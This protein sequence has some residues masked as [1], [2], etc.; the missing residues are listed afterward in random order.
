M[1]LSLIPLLSLLAVAFLAWAFWLLPREVFLNA[2]LIKADGA[3]DS[4]K[5]GFH[6][7]R[8]WIRFWQW[9]GCTAAGSLPALLWG[10]PWPVVALTFLGLGILLAGFFAAAFTPALN[11]ARGLDKWYVSFADRA[12]SWPDSKL[13]S[14]ARA[15]Y[16]ND[17]AKQVEYAAHALERLSGQTLFGTAAAAGLLIVAALVIHF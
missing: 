7:R 6:A 9:L 3:A 8:T 14:E 10:T 16:P 5:E 2:E 13:A 1:L 11:V 17:P 15:A 12:A 4:L